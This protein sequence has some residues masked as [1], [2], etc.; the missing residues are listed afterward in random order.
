MLGLCIDLFL[1]LGVEGIDKLDIF[2]IFGIILYN[3]LIAAVAPAVIKIS[4]IYKIS[5]AV[6]FVKHRGIAL[7]PA[8]IIYPFYNG[9]YHKFVV[10]CRLIHGKLC[11]HR[12]HFLCSFIAAEV[13]EVEIKGCK[14]RITRLYHGFDSGIHYVVNAYAVNDKQKHQKRDIICRRHKLNAVKYG[15]TPEK[16][17][18]RDHLGHK[19][20]TDY[21][22]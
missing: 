8:E 20:H 17:D 3:Q 19:K 18:K 7:I 13:I 1:Q 6:F 21:V 22:F 14:A 15:L 2:L 9:A 5:G 16:A 11:K 12:Q 10:V 4:N